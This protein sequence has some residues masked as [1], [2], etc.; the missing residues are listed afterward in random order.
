MTAKLEAAEDL[1]LEKAATHLLEECHR[2]TQPRS[3]SEAFLS[4]SSKLLMWSMAPL[5]IG[6]SVDIY[7][8]TRIITS[9][10]GIALACA[11]GALSV[12]A[13][14]WVL[15]PQRVRRNRPR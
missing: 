3:A 15:L 14:L 11:I 1:S 8:V 9:N 4:L 13:V 5:A 7:L 6:T 2:Q 12:F 10:P